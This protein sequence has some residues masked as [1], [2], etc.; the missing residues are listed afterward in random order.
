MLAE[1]SERITTIATLTVNLL[2]LAEPSERITTI[3][4]TVADMLLRIRRPRC[5]HAPGQG[6]R[7]G[8]LTGCR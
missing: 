6:L 7:R 8:R 2:M 1:L 3:A 5:R 4:T